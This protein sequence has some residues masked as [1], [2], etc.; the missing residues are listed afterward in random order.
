MRSL[1]QRICS[2]I[3][4]TGPISL[5]QYM[6]LA[7]ADPQH[8]YYQRQEAIGA[9]GDFITAPEV[10]Q[11][12]GELVGVWAASAWLA[13]G[14]PSPFLLVEAGPG[15]GVMMADALRAAASV[16]GFMEAVRISL[17]ETSPAMIAVQRQQLAAHK[18]STKWL[19]RLDQAED[20]P[21]IL[22]ANEFLDALP[23]RQ[24]VKAG[25]AWRERMVATDANGDLCAV[26]GP[27]FASMPIL[28]P[29]HQSEP[30]GSV[31]EHA[32]TREAFVAQIS[33]RLGANGGAALLI[34]YGH[35]QQG[36]GDTFQAVQ[37]HA[38]ADPFS[39]PGKADLTSHVDFAVL[40]QTAVE[41]GCHTSRIA[42]QGDFLV[43]MG[44]AERAGRLGA[45]KDQLAQSKI[46]KE[47]ERLVLPE[48]MG[49]LFKVLALCANQNAS[50]MTRLPPFVAGAKPNDASRNG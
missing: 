19:A 41:A 14:S 3:E 38:F 21:M 13:L 1:K 2:I 46:R 16:P 20:L 9:G 15:R 30:D 49:A 8:G 45:G 48:E 18:K 29:G 34:D 10:S 5:A 31:F 23:F 17:V 43:A 40:R 47:A 27:A 39:D 33:E 50:A 4:E 6:Q 28:P 36:F 24:Y 32:P 42:T 11:M 22:I 12:F 35:D 7:L 37:N 25:G 44:L 26:L